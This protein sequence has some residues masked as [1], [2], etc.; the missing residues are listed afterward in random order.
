[1]PYHFCS[2]KQTQQ[3][4]NKFCH[5]LLLLFG[6]VVGRLAYF[7]YATN[8]R[9][10]DAVGVVTYCPVGYLLERVRINGLAVSLDYDMIAGIAPLLY[11]PKI[12]KYAC[13]RC[14]CAAC[15]CVQDYAVNWSHRCLLVRA[16][17]ELPK[18]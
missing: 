9:N 13:S 6:S 18:E 16:V 1:M 2:R 10:V 7:I 12:P 17:Q 5:C 11:L 4:L 15:C 3:V 8:I 14:L